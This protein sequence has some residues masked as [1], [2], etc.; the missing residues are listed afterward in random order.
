MNTKEYHRRRDQL[1]PVV[2]QAQQQ[3]EVAAQSL[4]TATQRRERTVK[5]LTALQEFRDEYFQ[6]LAKRCEGSITARELHRYGEFFQQLDQGIDRVRQEI[7]YR[8]R[9]V[10]MKQTDWQQQYAKTEALK[11]VVNGYQQQNRQY[12]AR[13]EQRQLEEQGLQMWQRR[14][15]LGEF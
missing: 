7:G 13:Q 12:E 15:R 9:E 5:Q 3:Q 10:E 6:Q 14:Q 2:K 1:T 4:I 8:E 11:E